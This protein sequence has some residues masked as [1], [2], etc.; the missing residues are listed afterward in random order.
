LRDWRERNMGNQNFSILGEPE[1]SGPR[2]QEGCV[3]AVTV[4]GRSG[5]D[6]T[7]GD[8]V[9]QSTLRKSFPEK[10]RRT[11]YFSVQVFI[12]F[13]K[14]LNPVVVKSLIV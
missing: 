3:P 10:G 2:R 7:P 5:R 8:R 14:S 13:T 9:A 11:P 4:T 6:W 12:K 1:S